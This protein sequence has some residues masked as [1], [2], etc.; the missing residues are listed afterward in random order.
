MVAPAVNE[1]MT[2]RFFETPAH[3]MKNLPEKTCL[4]CGRRMVWRRRWAANWDEVRYC[5]AACQR[6][7]GKD[8]LDRELE[9]AIL[10]LLAGRTAGASICPS[11]AARRVFPV[12][13]NEQ[14]ERTRQAARRLVAAGKILITQG[15]CVVDPSLARGPIRLQLVPE[16]PVVPHDA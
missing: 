4:S 7:K 14:M 5:S 6:Q 1:L 10:S 13:W 3:A 16:K 9:M 12:D 2:E 11:E 15:G 8:P